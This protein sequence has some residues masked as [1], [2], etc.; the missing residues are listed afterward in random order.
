MTNQ[1]MLVVSTLLIFASMVSS[2]FIPLDGTAKFPNLQN[3][4]LKRC[5]ACIDSGLTWDAIGSVHVSPIS[6][7]AP[8]P[9]TSSSSTSVLGDVSH[10]TIDCSQFLTSVVANPPLESRPAMEDRSQSCLFP[11]TTLQD[12]PTSVSAL[13][14]ASSGVDAA[15]S[16]MN[17]VDKWRSAL[18]LP[19]LVQDNNLQNNAQKT[20]DESIGGLHHQLNPGSLAQ[21][22]APGDADNFEKVFVGGWLCELPDTPGLNGVCAEQ[23]KGWDYEGQ[24]GHAEIL[25]SGS[26]HKVGCAYSDGT[27]VWSCDL[28]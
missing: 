13:S 25:T 14:P 26:Y 20:A 5:W 9:P 6:D 1:K 8:N 7:S 27:G 2:V 16:Y 10:E 18:E 21:V 22:L 11:S 17:V 3:H 15:L 24:T 19:E 12:L 23:S 28:A 4:N